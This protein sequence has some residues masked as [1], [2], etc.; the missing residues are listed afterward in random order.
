MRVRSSPEI[1]KSLMCLIPVALK[2]GD[3]TSTMLFSS[4][5]ALSASLALKEP[6]RVRKPFAA[7][8]PPARVGSNTEPTKKLRVSLFREPP[9]L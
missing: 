6:I 2:I 7:F 9:T 4:L 8:L 3:R 5:A 1:P